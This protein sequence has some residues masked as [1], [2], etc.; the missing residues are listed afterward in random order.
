MCKSVISSRFSFRF[1]P[2]VDFKLAVWHKFVLTNFSLNI[3]CHFFSQF[4]T[5]VKEAYWDRLSLLKTK[6]HQ[7]FFANVQWREELFWYGYCN[8]YF[9]RSLLSKYNFAT[10][11]NHKCDF[12]NRPI[13]L[14]KVNLKKTFYHSVKCFV[15]LPKKEITQDDCRD[16]KIKFPALPYFFQL[17]IF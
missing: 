8:L 7:W 16:F 10:Q 1:S 15:N 6:M 2:S 5:K 13:C 17:A 9:F 3:N 14:Q 4:K 11:T 12:L